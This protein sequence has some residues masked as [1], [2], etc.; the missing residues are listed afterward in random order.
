MEVAEKPQRM[1]PMRSVKPTNGHI[2]DN[3]SNFKLSGTIS[4]G[5]NSLPSASS[6]DFK[7][8]ILNASDFN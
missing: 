1:E 2:N 8:A 3:G 7:R 5:D 6:H 4:N